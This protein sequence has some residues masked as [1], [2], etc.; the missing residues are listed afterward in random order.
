MGVE[1]KGW[2]R[3]A[4]I[5]PELLDAL[6]HGLEETRTLAEWLAVDARILV[7]EVFLGAGWREAAEGMGV[8][9]DGVVGLGV[10][11][12]SR[13]MGAG[14]ARCLAGLTRSEA[15]QWYERL[16]AHRSDVVR[17]WAAFADLA[18][19][20]LAF[21]ER[22]ERARRFAADGNMGVREVAWGMFRPFLEDDLDG[23]LERLG[24]WVRDGDPRIRRC[25]VEGTR[26]RGVW[27]RHLESMKRNPTLG[28]CLLEVVRSDES[29]Y[30]Q[31]S[32]ANWLNDASKSDPGWA[33]S[34]GQRWVRE[35]GTPS[36]R[37]LVRHGLRTL[38]K[39]G[40]DG[41]VA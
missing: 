13:A 2:S 36:T 21:G 24:V 4:D 8:V 3:R 16:A 41:G 31:L 12:R 7:R 10:M 5:P 17:C 20:G 25:A 38:R 18:T 9:A 32:V 33:V 29:R 28:L 40:E 30:V 39:R 11:D 6:N 14:L 37:W 23:A 1:R 26:P 15:M 22:L 34:V 27:T 19:P 35:S